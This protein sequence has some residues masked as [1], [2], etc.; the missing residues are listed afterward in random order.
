MKRRRYVV[1][2]AIVGAMLGWMTMPMTGA[3]EEISTVNSTAVLDSKSMSIPAETEE[4]APAADLTV[5]LYSK[6]V[7]RGYELSKGSMVIQPSMTVGYKGFGF[8]LWGNLDTDQ[9]EKL[10]GD[11]G[12]NWN[13]TDMTISYDGAYKIV[14]YSAGY[15]YYALDAVA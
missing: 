9:N 7:W 3:A 10:Y 8:N 13:E 1:P 6:Y 14:G 11:T 2:A 15:I 4:E 5:G 12:S